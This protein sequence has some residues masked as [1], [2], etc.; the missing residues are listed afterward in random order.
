MLPLDL[1]LTSNYRTGVVR[2]PHPIRRLIDEGIPVTLST[3]DP[4]L[5]RI[6]LPREYRRARR[7]FGISDTEIVR[8]ASDGI[9][10]SFADE[11]TKSQLDGALAKRLSKSC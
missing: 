1:A 3:D 10:F 8:I 5:F 9:R 6:D 2:G 7:I 11:K 4:S